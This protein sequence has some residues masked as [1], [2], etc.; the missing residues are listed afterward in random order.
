MA[1]SVAQQKVIQA[2]RDFAKGVASEGKNLFE[3]AQAQMTGRPSGERLGASQ[4][5]SLPDH[6]QF[7]DTE[8]YKQKLET[9]TNQRIDELRVRFQEEVKNARAAR[10][11]KAQEVSQQQT[12]EMQAT[13]KPEEEKKG[14]LASLGRAAKRV[15]GRL[16][17]V[18]KG[19]M[20][21]GRG[22]G[23]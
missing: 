4:N 20:E 16:G 19:K 6:N 23:G 2:Q 8:A 5:V 3:T 12:R 1:A 10:E 7:N 11:Q 15:K 21:K 14:I 13:E 17:Q 18:G 22:G 9:V